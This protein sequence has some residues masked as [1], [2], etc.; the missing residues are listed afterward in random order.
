[1][2]FVWSRLSDGDANFT[3]T[4]VA[5]ND[6]IMIFPFAPIEGLLLSLSAITVTWG[7][8]FLSVVRYVV[9]PVMFAQWWRRRL[10]HMG[11]EATLEKLLGKLHP[12]SLV[13][14]LATLVLLF[15][16]QGEQ[17]LSQPLAIVMLAVAYLL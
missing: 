15:G 14:L 4:Q 7:N 11:G 12:V 17:I 6:T 10:L 9:L 5:P 3:L 16:F 1:M 2:V 13:S 8:L